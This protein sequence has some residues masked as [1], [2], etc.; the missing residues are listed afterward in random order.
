MATQVLGNQELDALE[1]PA[2]SGSLAQLLESYESEAEPQFREGEALSFSRGK[3]LSGA[4]G[5]LVAIGLEG[6][7]LLSAFGIW[8]FFRLLR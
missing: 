2:F 5:F 6:A 1:A 4:R 8:Q 7:V 3:G